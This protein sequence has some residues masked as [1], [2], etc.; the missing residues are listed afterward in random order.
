MY[1]FKG[2]MTETDYIDYNIF[3]M[4]NSKSLKRANFAL[5]F[6]FPIGF[7]LLI[8]M[9]ESEFNAIYWTILVVGTIITFRLLPK[10]IDKSLKKRIQSML[11]DG[12]NGDLFEEHDYYF[13]E[14]GI[15]MESTNST[16]LYK[17]NSVTKFVESETTF[18]IY[19]NSIQALII[20]KYYLEDMKKIDGFREY[21]NSMIE[22][23]RQIAQ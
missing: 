12:K 23:N 6:I 19:V 8:V 17:W 20:P 7:T 11:D 22:Y 4:N 5:K 9:T 2:S 13:D 14:S 10:F 18:Y 21:I 15:K 3:H 16:N 1:T